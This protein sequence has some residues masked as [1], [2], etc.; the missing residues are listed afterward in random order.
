[1]GGEGGEAPVCMCKVKGSQRQG[2]GVGK[3]GDTHGLL[4]LQLIMRSPR[5]RLLWGFPDIL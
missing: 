5:R 1:M 4:S 2:W 3:I